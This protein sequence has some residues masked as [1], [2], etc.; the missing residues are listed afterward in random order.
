MLT[1]AGTLLGGL[2]LFLLAVGL[3]T[4]GL[5]QAAGN[6][7]RTILANWTQTDLRGIASGFLITALVQSSSA[8][9]VATVGFVNAGLLSMRQALGVVYG[10]NIGTTI[11]AWLVA[12]VGFKLD[13]QAFALPMIGVGMVIR[14]L[15]PDGRAAAYGLALVGFGLFFVGIDLLKGA[16]EGLVA[17]FDVSTLATT[18]LRSV[19]LFLLAG[20][21][22]TVLAQSSSASIAITIAAASS[23]LVSLN[24]AAAMI[25]GAN[26]GT[27]STALLASI[28]ATSNSRRVALAQVIF[29]VGT[30]VVALLLLPLL[31][32]L[33]DALGR[34]LELDAEPA[35]TLALFHTVFNVLGVLLVLPFNNRLASWLE[36]RFRSR[37]AAPA[38]PRFIDSTV[39]ATPALAVNA[40]VQ[41]LEALAGRTA[42]LALAVSRQQL[43]GNG[44]HTESTHIRQ[45]AA[46]VSHFLMEVS[47][48]PLSEESTQQLA[49][50]LRVDQYL[51]SCLHEI[52]QL[53]TL[54]VSLD[55]QLPL[56][57]RTELERFRQRFCGVLE[58]DISHAELLQQD[59]EQAQTQLQTEHDMLKARLLVVTTEH[60]LPF[61]E[62][63]V[64]VELAA[65]QLHLARQWL[66][67]M[68]Y[69][70]R[71]HDVTGITDKLT[72]SR[73]QPGQETA[74]PGESDEAV[75]LEG[76]NEKT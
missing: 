14:L 47:R 6:S 9:T 65:L 71:L 68:R 54:N 48:E 16:F 28:G 70:Q 75:A 61:E 45:L 32:L 23:G 5:K 35:V 74:D 63:L 19:L 22:M 44:L 31:F 17:T 62:M 3:M 10:S 7:L 1:V 57:V 69:L 27:T 60:Q 11:T 2:G 13:V 29:N 58:S 33:L 50:L 34:L 49:S 36:Q 43:D 24:A 53:Y 41:E 66:K 59:F 4:D 26:V 76:E 51:L 56:A 55:G 72:D 42:Q 73:D 67:A 40:L 39:A 64:Q 20:I 8:V 37:E 30:G 25:I 21:A 52:N 12:A 18:G 38:L 15:R 46:A